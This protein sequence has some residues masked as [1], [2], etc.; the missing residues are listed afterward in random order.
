MA[1]PTIATRVGGLVDSVVDGETGILVNPGDPADLAR[2]ILHLLRDPEEAKRLGAAGRRRMLSG[3]TLATTA[4]KLAEFYRAQRRAAPGAYRLHV[5]LMRLATA[6]LV[7]GP[8]LT[9]ILL[10][11]LYRLKRPSGL[12]PLSRRR[13]PAG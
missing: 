1:R 10:I 5:S 6:L 4:T 3:F 13:R 7:H 12:F 11:E 9:A 2:A 8:R